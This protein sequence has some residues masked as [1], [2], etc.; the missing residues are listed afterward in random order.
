MTARQPRR[1][2]RRPLPATNLPRP[3]QPPATGE[4]Q[5]DQGDTGEAV[6]ETT[7]RGTRRRRT[8]APRAH[9]VTTDFSYVHKDLATVA[10]V[11]TLILAFIIAISFFV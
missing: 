5:A 8:T 2:R 10:V 9:H 3:H 7:A 1:T 4:D 6:A 11:G